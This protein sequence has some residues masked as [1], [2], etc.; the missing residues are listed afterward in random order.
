M[1]SLPIGI[2]LNTLVLNIL[3][4]SKILKQSH[5]PITLLLNVHKF[6]LNTYSFDKYVL[7]TYMARKLISLQELRV[8]PIKELTFNEHLPK[9]TL[10]IIQLIVDTSIYFPF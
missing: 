5:C 2:Y 4:R 10:G 9:T 6:K 1:T 3:Y 7:L 8:Y